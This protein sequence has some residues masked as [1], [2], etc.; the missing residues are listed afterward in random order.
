MGAGA[1]Q[2]GPRHVHPE[3]ARARHQGADA[4]IAILYNTPPWPRTQQRRVRRGG[5]SYLGAPLPIHYR[6][7][8]APISYSF[9]GSA[10]MSH[11]TK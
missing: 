1:N 8:L 2:P 6:V 3:L 11:F 5:A 4:E 9:G 7:A 10:F